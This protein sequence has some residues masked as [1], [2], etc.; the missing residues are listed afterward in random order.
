[1]AKRLLIL[2]RRPN[3]AP[4]RQRI[5]PYLDPLRETGIAP[6]VEVL[7]TAAWARRR[8]FRRARTFDGLLLHRKTLTWWEARA[9]GPRRG[10][11]P[12]IYDFDDAVMFQA[13]RPGRVHPGRAR[14]FARTVSAADL[15]LAGS[16]VL[17]DHAREAGARR[18]EVVP[19]GLDTARYPPKE[20]YETADGPRL[21]WIGSRSTLKQLARLRQAL[22]AVGRAVPGARLRVIADAP[23]AV[24]DLEVENVP[25]SRET[26]GRLLAACDVG[27]APLPDTAYTRGKCGFKVVQY[28]AAGLPVVA[29]PVGVQA[30]YVRPEESGLHATGKAEWVEAIRRL[31]GDADLRRR[32]GQA[33][34]ARV[35]A[36]FDLRVLATRVEGLVGEAMG[37]T[38]KQ[39]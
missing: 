30:D 17:A 27:I 14:R 18:V 7:A 11:G 37:V 39:Q 1:M 36:A 9:L 16:T 10:R 20:A 2:T 19:T 12:L 5:A 29:S 31:A 21:V 34:R 8:P 3:G 26:E 13:R 6:A 15:V 28:M 23:L 4:F 25:W 38:A 32:F 24:E 35:E 33:G 22:A